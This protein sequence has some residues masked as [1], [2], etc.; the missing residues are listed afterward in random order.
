MFKWHVSG[1]VGP[2]P[3]F[4]D[5]CLQNLNPQP[6]GLINATMIKQQSFSSRNKKDS[7]ALP[8]PP[9][10][11]SNNNSV[12]L[13]GIPD[14]ICWTWNFV[15]H[16]DHHNLRG[17]R[18]RHGRILLK[19]PSL[20]ETKTSLLLLKL[21]FFVDS[22]YVFSSSSV[23]LGVLN[24]FSCV[25]PCS[26]KHFLNLPTVWGL[27]WCNLKV[28][29]QSLLRQNQF[30]WFKITLGVSE[31]TVPLN[32]MVLLIIIPFLNG[33]FIGNINPTFS[34]KPIF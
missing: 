18:S 12:W 5:L 16:M 25:W 4:L 29:I 8:F 3:M 23:L 34:D 11:M 10:L 28:G 14:T 19:V 9:T 13:L 24:D 1:F 33:Y 30:F 31:N 20:V 7:I 2:P 27:R 6:P 15:D 17:W 26:S 21:T 22:N 32:P